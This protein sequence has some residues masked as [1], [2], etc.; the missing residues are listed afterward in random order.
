MAMADGTGGGGGGAGA[1][2]SQ[3][4]VGGHGHAG[5]VDD[6]GVEAEADGGKLDV[7]I[8]DVVAGDAEEVAVKVGN[9]VEVEPASEAGGTESASEA[10]DAAHHTELASEAGN[11]EPA[12]EAG[13]AAHHTELAPE[14]G[15][16]EPAPEAGDAAHHTELAPKA[17]NPEPAPEAGDA[18]HHTELASEAGN[19]EPAPEAGDAAHHTELAPEAGNPEPAPEAGDAAHHTELAPE[20]GNPEPAPEAGYAAHH[21]ELA[22]EAG[23]PEPAPEAGDAAHHTELAP[24]AGNPEPAPEA[25][26]AAHHTELAPVAG[27]PEPAPEAGDAAHHTELAPE[28]GNPEPAPEAGDAT[29]TTTSATPLVTRE[30]PLDAATLLP[31]VDIIHAATSAASTPGDIPWA[32]ARG[33]RILCARLS[34]V[35]RLDQDA[36][37]PP[38]ADLA[39][40]LAHLHMAIHSPSEADVAEASDHCTMVIRELVAAS[41]S[42]ALA[43]SPART[44]AA[45]DLVDGLCGL[46]DS[47]LLPRA[48]DTELWLP[49]ALNYTT[50]A[51]EL[52]DKAG[53]ADAQVT[54]LTALAA[55][56]SHQ[57]TSLP[58][59]RAYANGHKIATLYAYSAIQV[60]DD[61]GLT[62][63]NVHAA[64]LAPLATTAAF[65]RAVAAHPLSPAG[66]ALLD[67][68][69]SPLP[70]ADLAS[71][72]WFVNRGTLHFMRYFVALLYQRFFEPRVDAAR[73]A[74]RSLEAVS[75]VFT[76]K[77]TALLVTEGLVP[78][79]AAHGS[80]RQ[81]AEDAD[82]TPA[83]PSSVDWIFSLLA[84]H[85]DQFVHVLQRDEGIHVLMR[86]MG[87]MTCAL[88]ETLIE[89]A[90]S[91]TGPRPAHGLSLAS[92]RSLA[93]KCPHI[94]SYFQATMELLELQT[95][96]LGETPFLCFDR[97]QRSVLKDGFRLD[98]AALSP[99]NTITTPGELARRQVEVACDL[100][101][102]ADVDPIG[103]GIRSGCHVAGE[104][105][106]FSD[107]CAALADV[108][109]SKLDDVLPTSNNLILQWALHNRRK[110]E[111]SGMLID[112]PA[113][114]AAQDLLDQRRR[115]EADNY[116]HYD[117]DGTTKRAKRVRRALNAPVKIVTRF[118][119]SR[120]DGAAGDA[121]PMSA[122]E[123]AAC[124]RDGRQ[125]QLSS[126][127]AILP[128]VALRQFYAIETLKR[129]NT[130]HGVFSP[131]EVPLAG[132]LFVKDNLCR[133]IA[134]AL[135]GLA[136]YVGIACASTQGRIAALR[137][138]GVVHRDM[139]RAWAKFHTFACTIRYKAHFMHGC[140]EES[141]WY[142]DATPPATLSQLVQLTRDDSTY[143]RN[144]VTLV[145]HPLSAMLSDFTTSWG[146]SAPFAAMKHMVEARWA[147]KMDAI[148]EVVS[149]GELVGDARL[150][151]YAAAGPQAFIGVRDGRV[152]R[153]RDEFAEELFTATGVT[154]TSSHGR[155]NVV[156]VGGFHFKQNPELPGAE[157]AVHLLAHL[158]FGDGTPPTDLIRVRHIN[159][160]ADYVFQVS[161]TVPGPILKDVLASAL[162][163]PGLDHA[164]FSQQVLLALITNPEDGKLD[165]YVVEDV[166]E[167]G[168]P[169]GLVRRPVPIDNDHAFV[170]PLIAHRLSAAQARVKTVLFCMADMN[171][172]ID[173][174]VAANFTR[175]DAESVLGHWLA[176]LDAYH[177][178]METIAPPAIIDALATRRNFPT[179][180]EIRF[181]PGLV[182][183]I[184]NKILT[185]QSAI[186]SMSEGE[187][188]TLRDLLQ[189]GEPTLAPLYATVLDNESLPSAAA[190]FAV[191][192]SGQYKSSRG[193]GL[194]TVTPSI[195]IQRN[196]QA[197]VATSLAEEKRLRRLH[198]PPKAGL[199]WRRKSARDLA[200]EA[201]L[202]TPIE[203]TGELSKLVKAQAA[204]ALRDLMRGDLAAFINLRLSQFKEDVVSRVDFAS[205]D[206]L[207]QG[208]LFDAMSGTYFR[209]LT[210][211]GSSL[212]TDTMLSAILKHCRNLT[213]LDVSGCEKLVTLGDLAK[214]ASNLRVLVAS[215]TRVTD[216]VL[217]QVERAAP[218]LAVCTL[219]NA[220]WAPLRTFVAH[221]PRLIFARTPRTFQH[222]LRMLFAFNSRHRPITH[223]DLRGC[224]LVDSQALL[225]VNAMS[226]T[227]SIRTLNVAHN[228][229]TGDVAWDLVFLILGSDTPG[230]AGPV[231]DG[232][233]NAFGSAESESIRGNAVV[234]I[235][236]SDTPGCAEPVN[237]GGD[238]GVTA[239]SGS[240]HGS[241]SECVA[242][243]SCSGKESDIDN[244]A[245]DGHSDPI[246]PVLVPADPAVELVAVDISYNPLTQETYDRIQTVVSRLAELPTVLADTLYRQR[247]DDADELG[248]APEPIGRV[249][250]SMRQLV[251]EANSWWMSKRIVF[252]PRAQVRSKKPRRAKIG[253]GPGGGLLGGGETRARAVS[254]RHDAGVESETG[255][256]IS[257]AGDVVRETTAVPLFKLPVTYGSRAESFQVGES[258]EVTAMA[259]LECRDVVAVAV[260]LPPCR[261]A[262]CVE[263]YG[264]KA[265]KFAGEHDGGVVVVFD[266]S[267][268]PWTV[269]ITLSGP[270]YV[271]TALMWKMPQ[272][273]LV[274]GEGSQ[275]SRD[276]AGNL[277]VWHLRDVIHDPRTRRVVTSLDEA[278]ASP[279]GRSSVV[280]PT[281]YRPVVLVDTRSS[282]PAAR[283]EVI[284]GESMRRLV[285]IAR[286]GLV[287]Y[288]VLSLA[289][290][291]EKQIAV[292]RYG[293]NIEM[294]HWNELPGDGGDSGR[295]KLHLGDELDGHTDA[296]RQV[297]PTA[298]GDLVSASY[299][300]TVR[301]WS[302]GLPLDTISPGIGD[303][304]A[305]VVL[306]DG[307][308]VVG[309]HSGQLAVVSLK[310][311]YD[312]GLES[313]VTRL[314]VAHTGTVVHLQQLHDG[315]V[316]SSAS[317]KP[318]AD[319]LAHLANTVCIFDVDVAA[320]GGSA[321][322]TFSTREAIVGV[323]ET[324]DGSLQL[325]DRGGLVSRVDLEHT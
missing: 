152:R 236:G 133:F 58:P 166:V 230:S 310:Q 242:G 94:L 198:A 255:S 75:P 132:E 171:L 262:L 129:N 153:L 241:V 226:A 23:N 222:G 282:E 271:V 325:V 188:L 151:A 48:L 273:Q 68:Y 29:H 1:C 89:D 311:P 269:L 258:L 305:M 131:G 123:L 315:R 306:A 92:A 83:P 86:L 202:V 308:L 316:L 39:L 185:L 51:F 121:A 320:T 248:P 264:H 194:V 253:G 25:G 300:G 21:T 183:V 278:E 28:A 313:S 223:L 187:P 138:A 53:L 303:L 167:P 201:G 322:L 285:D 175:V 100:L 157:L 251:E 261:C 165:N 324:G 56:Y 88:L 221:D 127:Q 144:A 134:L 47:F 272:R 96:G 158:V 64:A 160:D 250:H 98:V 149:D 125:V 12:P 283:S 150:S 24:E 205:L 208:H 246:P 155:R 286:P 18:A 49:P 298:C 301:L 218:D 126:E 16:P 17:G 172:P 176:E 13:D 189:A 275:Q 30:T 179:T 45:F 112:N 238:A 209:K 257:V 117:D 10:G 72:P 265:R 20:A 268:M 102:G 191:I 225:L 80:S 266:T 319:S 54:L 290:L 207:R 210:I 196:Q 317:G 33:L 182:F 197:Y 294:W 32:E 297:A 106:L 234:P 199:S 73:L 220:K 97:G 302:R 307:R 91:I 169:N 36:I 180:L 99:V 161:E 124:I 43:A 186:T 224:G 229:I 206:P 192:S 292:G 14:A 284:R 104:P 8:A 162:E 66:A 40:R 87:G 293:H 296:V 77:L 259:Q 256:E 181:K 276:S 249:E 74:P 287:S 101:G 288:P 252:E 38:L 245:S 69:V 314:A 111:A 270:G 90:M 211:Q 26:D 122:E 85:Q 280:L 44:A 291:D 227:K 9:L 244:Q 114:A 295:S 116:Y 190:R 178:R 76:R 146:E 109:A 103:H 289:Q 65:M 139:A 228:A 46:I 213:K 34:L 260:R 195:Q 184:F 212:L 110:D 59:S 70:A 219:S 170:A 277:F 235:L 200:R 141:V 174:V 3:L 142:A 239:S 281:I 93:R 237:D 105:E 115:D 321:D 159:D 214:Y 35:D 233:S 156:Q 120:G 263:Q 113:I 67:A 147:W 168:A 216:A 267:T 71:L 52:A 55:L 247:A 137:D 78:A 215:G 79:S 81:A 42:E 318:P 95:I 61:A 107:Y 163:V 63:D 243:E 6:I 118:A 31:L 217:D 2:A 164:Y 57:A 193:G 82:V 22:R 240:P 108:F 135:D 274:A 145:L 323:I 60:A 232:G 140:E 11:P 4:Q 50:A 279:F 309:G 231:S 254:V 304:Y 177:R 62:G 37:I 299:D 27:N 5:G 173:P 84:A 119:R 312:K 130:A 41:H 143:L 128:Y 204:N 136:L 148:A 203:L 15:N 19:L 7:T 154:Q